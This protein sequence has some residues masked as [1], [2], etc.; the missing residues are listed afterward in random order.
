MRTWVDFEMVKEMDL[1]LSDHLFGKLQKLQNS[2]IKECDRC[3][4]EVEELS[5]EQIKWI[6]FD[7]RFGLIRYFA[8]IDDSY[9][10]PIPPVSAG[11]T[12]P[13]RFIVENGVQMFAEFKVDEVIPPPIFSPKLENRT[14]LVGLMK[15]CITLDQ[16]VDMIFGPLHDPFRGTILAKETEPPLPPAI[17]EIIRQAAR[18][19][20]PKE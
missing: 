2:I 19:V 4:E 6:F 1:G 12:L 18:P 13:I 3:Y 17:Q 15:N 9:G 10:R 20:Q 5:F 16:R 8:S 14:I 11:E 7:K